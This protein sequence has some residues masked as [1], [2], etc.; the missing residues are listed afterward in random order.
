M[1]RAAALLALLACSASLRAQ[2]SST[3]E[4]DRTGDPYD[5]PPHFGYVVQTDALLGPEAEPEGFLLRNA[6]VRF[7]E[8]ASPV[9]RYFVQAELARAPSVLDARIAVRV[10]GPLEVVAGLYKAPFSREFLIFRGALPLA[11][12]ARVVSALAPRR[13]VGASLR[14]AGPVGGADGRAEVG[15]YNGNGGRTLSADA[16]GPLV[17]G[18]AEASWTTGPGVLRVGASAAYGEDGA[19]PIPLFDAPFAGT[20]AV[21]GADVELATPRLYV[22][23][24][25]IAAR[26]DSGS[27][28]RSPWGGAVTASFEALQHVRIVGRADVLDADPEGG[29]D[30]EGR[31]RFTAG[32]DFEPSPHVRALADYDFPATAPGDGVLRLRLQLALR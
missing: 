31:A 28:V 25:G 11:E 10:A 15:L 4:A 8:E 13:Q 19:A 2:P 26:F 9:A 20:R 23:A 29:G 7:G 17:V 1:T 3:A 24:E 27:G 30:S 21:G 12:R 6:R 16:G 14:L 32:L 5:V 22:L 18:R